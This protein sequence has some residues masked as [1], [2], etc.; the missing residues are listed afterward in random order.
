MP[1]DDWLDLNV[2]G[3]GGTG[4][5]RRG[6]NYVAATNRGWRQQR[7]RPAS[8]GSAR[9]VQSIPRGDV[10]TQAGCSPTPPHPRPC[11]CSCS[12]VARRSRSPPSALAT[13]FPSSSAVP[14]PRQDSLSGHPRRLVPQPPELHPQQPVSCFAFAVFPVPITTSPPLNQFF[15]DDLTRTQA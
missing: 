13:G 9:G 14:P 12:P 11:S 5:A 8:V 7:H 3:W 15:L 10:E 1:C 2:E 6:T 4:L